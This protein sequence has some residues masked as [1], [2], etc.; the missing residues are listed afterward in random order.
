MERRRTA[1]LTRRF[2]AGGMNGDYGVLSGS[3]TPY[4]TF[5]AEK[6]LQ[7]FARPG[8]SVLNG[9][10]DIAFAFRLCRTSHQWRSHVARHQQ[11]HDH[12]PYCANRADQ[13]CAL[14]ECH[15]SILRH[16]AGS[17][18]GKQCRGFTA[19]HRDDEFFNRRCELRLYVSALVVDAFHVDP[20]IFDAVRVGRPA[21]TGT[22]SPSRSARHTLCH[23]KF[24]GFDDMEPGLDQQTRGEHFKYHPPGPNGFP[25]SILPRF[26]AALSLGRKN[27]ADGGG[28]THT[29]LRVPDFESGASANSATSATVR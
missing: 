24:A 23:S 28:R 3:N 22:A 20:G 2:M 19:G 4:P 8:D 5:Y 26:L 7:Y 16:P 25:V 15:D 1:I 27:G 18:G 29:L 11:G 13:L 9:T 17:G 14:H 21:W 12:E 10:S 6:L